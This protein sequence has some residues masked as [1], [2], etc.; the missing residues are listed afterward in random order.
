MRKEGDGVIAPQKIGH[1]GSFHKII[2][3]G[4]LTSNKFFFKELR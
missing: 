4:S 1:E 3:F 2:P